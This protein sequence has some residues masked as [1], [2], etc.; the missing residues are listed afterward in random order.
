MNQLLLRPTS[1]KEFIG[2]KKLIITLKAMIDGSL[3]RNEVL[4]H[5]LF[6]GPP[7]TG[8]TTLASLIG[9]ELNKRVHYLQGALLE[10]KSD[11][12]SVFAN[13]NEND[14]VFIDEIHSINRAVEE[15]IYNAMEDFKIDLIIGPEGNS[16][17]M[18]MN[19]K[20]FTLVG[21]TIKLNLLS[22]P[23]K[24]RFG[25][26]ARLSQYSNEEIVKILQNSKKKLKVETDSD[27]LMLLA[28]YSRNTPRIANH[29]LKRAYDFSL[30]NNQSI[31]DAKTTYLTFKHLELFD[32]GLNKEHIEYLSLLSNS[33]YD[34]FVSI[35]A[36]SGILNMSKENLINDI[37]PYL[38]YL[39]L[40]EKSPRGRR[41][42]TKGVD[43][44]IRNNLNIYT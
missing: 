17:V 11:V 38:L 33:F 24:D 34:K 43:Y 25:L 18:R 16:K 35:D 5:I 41:I 42:T 3:H 14:I 32:L 9:N 21:A 7:G 31:I 37:E 39:Q 15:I 30:K 26:L 23:F 28:K 12:L 1:F 29:L 6:Y 20:P 2:Q 44:L 27:V 8:K 22:Q 13:V 4:D 36:I 40:I 19:L 10:K